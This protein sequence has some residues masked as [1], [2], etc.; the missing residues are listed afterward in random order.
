ME[1]DFQK[2]A[3]EA[4]NQQDDDEESNDLEHESA[5]RVQG[6]LRMAAA[7]DRTNQA[8]QQSNLSRV[9]PNNQSIRGTLSPQPVSS[10]LQST[11]IP[12]HTATSQIGA[13]GGGNTYPGQNEGSVISSQQNQSQHGSI[14]QGP[15]SPMYGSTLGQLGGGQKSGPISPAQS[16]EDR[17]RERRMEE[18]KRKQAEFDENHRKR[19]ED[20]RQQQQQLQ[21]H[22]QIQLQQQIYQ[23]QQQQQHQSNLRSQHQLHPGMLRLDNLVINGPS[24]P[25]CKWIDQFLAYEF[26]FYK[27]FS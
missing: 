7:Q 8:N 9:N 17:D 26:L 22:Q 25:P 24:S 20:I 10:Q 23:Q 2:R 1:R 12:T 4:A 3:E 6:L 18:L 11:N 15:V 5:Q 14:G 27:Y 13:P 16:N 21:M 19:E